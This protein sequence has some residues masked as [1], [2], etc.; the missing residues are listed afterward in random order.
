MEKIRLPAFD[1]IY[2]CDGR[3][4]SESSTCT[5]K[6]CLWCN[7]L[8]A[9]PTALHIWKEF[10]EHCRVGELTTV[11]PVKRCHQ[12]TAGC[13]IIKDFL[14]GLSIKL[15]AKHE[16]SDSVRRCLR[17]TFSKGLSLSI[18]VFAL[19][20]TFSCNKRGGDAIQFAEEDKG[21]GDSAEDY[22]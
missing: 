16:I 14:P 19:N 10:Q 17:N 1:Q 12:S 21:C 20:W 4:I 15:L 18:N 6:K 22:M 13:V 9:Q 7:N 2:T 3:E 5:D 8:K 11:R